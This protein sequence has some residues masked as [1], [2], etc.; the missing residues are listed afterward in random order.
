MKIEE[1]ME[2]FKSLSRS[3]GFYGR[4]LMDIESLP[5][6]DYDQLVITLEEQDFKDALELIMWVEG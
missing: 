6:D 2:V 3:Q 1:I 5:K 4:L